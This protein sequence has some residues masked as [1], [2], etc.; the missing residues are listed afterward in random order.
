[1]DLVD[2]I[3]WNIVKLF[4]FSNV[5]AITYILF[6]KFSGLFKYALNIKNKYSKLICKL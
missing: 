5:E 6:I 3:E 4:S 1:M 2:F